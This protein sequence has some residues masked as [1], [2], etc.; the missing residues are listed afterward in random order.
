M[1]NRSINLTTPREP[2]LGDNT[3]K[4]KTQ[5]ATIKEVVASTLMPGL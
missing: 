3:Q 1:D 4:D 5:I 2:E